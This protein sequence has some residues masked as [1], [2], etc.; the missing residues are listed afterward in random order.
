MVRIILI[1]IAVLMIYVSYRMSKFSKINKDIY[2]DELKRRN[3]NLE[4]LEK[5]KE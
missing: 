5:D 2:R 4:P 1:A 3:S